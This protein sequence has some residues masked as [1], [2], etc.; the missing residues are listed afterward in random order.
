MNPGN[1]SSS[2]KIPICRLDL[3]DIFLWVTSAAVTSMLG[4]RAAPLLPKVNILAWMILWIGSVVVYSGFRSNQLQSGTSL[5]GFAF[6]GGVI[7]KIGPLPLALEEAGTILGWW[8]LFT[9]GLLTVGALNLNI[10]RCGL[11]IFS[12]IYPAGWVFLVI[13]NE[14]G[15]IWLIWSLLGG[16]I[17]SVL[18]ANT[19]RKAVQ[20]EAPKGYPLGG[21]LYLL[22]FN[23]L[24]ISNATA[25]FWQELFRTEG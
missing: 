2:G 6:S 16:T 4:Y 5:F 7:L 3:P 18:I 17:F 11:R 23:L 25:Y 12:V 9:F 14:T 19:V 10:L 20:K 22:L 24:L 1:P 15:L 8:L 21:S 13:S